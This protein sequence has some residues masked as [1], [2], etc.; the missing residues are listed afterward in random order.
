MNFGK[1]RRVSLLASAVGLAASCLTAATITGTV[2]GP[3]GAP[4]RGAFVQAQN[5]QTHITVNVLSGP[6]GKYR[7]EKLPAGEYTVR[8][9]AVGFKADPQTGV[10]LTTDQNASMD[11]ALQQGLVRWNDLS[12]LQGKVLF[13]DGKGKQE[14]VTT[15]FGCHGFETR[16]ASVHRDADG[17]V[18]RVNYM[19]EITHFATAPAFTDEKAADVAAYLNTLLAMLSCFPNRPLTCLATRPRCGSSAMKP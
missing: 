12:Y 19:K 10:K 2:K 3:D 18:D 4:F 5:S 11:I 8:I 7:V 17:W 9:R 14:L 15:C 6:D 13:P 16:M 1:L